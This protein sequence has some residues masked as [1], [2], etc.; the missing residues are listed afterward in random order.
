MP[1]LKDVNAIIHI[2]MTLSFD[3]SCKKFVQ[4]IE[5]DI[6]CTGIQ[7]TDRKIIDLS[8]EDNTIAIDDTR[9]QTWFMN[10]WCESKFMQDS[11]SMLFP[12]TG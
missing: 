4:Q 11:I 9:V 2:K 8:H 7:S 6:S 10:G 3:G 12:K 5:E 1:R